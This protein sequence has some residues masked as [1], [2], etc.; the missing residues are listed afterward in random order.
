METVTKLNKDGQVI[1]SALVGAT[2]LAITMV[3]FFQFLSKGNQG[4]RQVSS[5]GD[6]STLKSNVGLVFQSP[7]NCS[8]SFRSGNVDA[9]FDPAA[10]SPYPASAPTE[11]KLGTMSV[12]GVGDKIGNFIVSAITI[13]KLNG[14][15]PVAGSAPLQNSYSTKVN[16][17]GTLAP[18]L[19]G[20]G[21]T[22]K[23]MEFLVKIRTLAGS[24]PET[25]VGCGELAAVPIETCPAGG[26]YCNVTDFNGS[27]LQIS[28]EIVA[29]NN[30]KVPCSYLG[31]DGNHYEGTVKCPP[32]YRAIGGG[33]NC[34]LPPRGGF[35]LSSR[36]NKD[37]T[38]WTADCCIDIKGGEPLSPNPDRMYVTCLKL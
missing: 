34:Q 33:V 35:M 3:A 28:G 19:A 32:G 8:Y 12:V 27:L 29:A 6:W 25:I 7:E 22:P 18:H 17:T 36:A 1:L 13:E 30:P 15:D 20:S 14:P 24:L 10:P 37:G 4:V 9:A 11:I 5:I 16:I 31:A 23:R 2:I 38:G 21:L 26:S